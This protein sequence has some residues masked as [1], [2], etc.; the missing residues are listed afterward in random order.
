MPP[1]QLAP[2]LWRIRVPLPFRLREVNLYLL[3]GEH[4]YTLIDAGID[5]ADARAAFD[6]A[7]AEL[8]VPDTA[9]E[10]VYVTHMHPD[11]IGMSG[12]RAAAGSRIFLLG[13]EERR[14]RF[15]WGTEPLSD[16]ITYSREH[17]AGGEIA[18]G[19]VTAVNGLRRAVTLPERFEH[20]SDGDVVEAGKRRLRVVWTP[21]HSDFHYVLVDDDARVVFCGDQLL[22]TI[23]P[24]I[25]L[26]PECR[27]NPLEDFLWSLGR[28]ERESAYAVLPGHGESYATLPERIGQFRKHHDERLAG[29]RSQV[30]ASDGAGVTA[31]EVVRHFWG[32][33]LS[34]HEIRFALVEVVAHLEYLRLG[35]GLARTD[36]SGVYRYRVA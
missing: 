31:F 2:D 9:I 24:N 35:G 15:V 16:W 30:A 5:T 34:T 26:Y 23:T 13:Q 36:D 22:P 19:I 21:G 6:A 7:L 12:R 18:E 3:R 33:K 14:A 11:H 17:G 4:G 20:L 10:R 29:V 8:R 1:E 27:P 25:G 32:D 28:F